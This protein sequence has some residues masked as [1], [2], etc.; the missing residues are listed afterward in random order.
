M[1]TVVRALGFA[2]V[3]IAALPAHG[4]NAVTASALLDACTRAD[5]HWVD[6]CNGYFQAVHDA[7]AIA[8][9]VCVPHGTTRTALVEIFEAEAPLILA[10]DPA[11]AQ[12]PAYMLAARILQNAMPCS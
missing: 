10:A 11:G 8:G 7:L 3:S 1:A 4:Q 6:F 12:M 5:M 9:L 2:A